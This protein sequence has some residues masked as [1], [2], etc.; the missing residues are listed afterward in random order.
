VCTIRAMSDNLVE[1]A[2]L[3]GVA[4]GATWLAHQAIRGAARNTGVSV[5]LIAGMV[6]LAARALPQADG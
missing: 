6:Y 1:A 4:V 5:A 3:V 2:L